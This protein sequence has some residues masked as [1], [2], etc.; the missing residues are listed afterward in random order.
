MEGRDAV[1]HSPTY[2]TGMYHLDNRVL[3]C[4]FWSKRNLIAIGVWTAL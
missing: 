3:P 2:L 1:E 4:L